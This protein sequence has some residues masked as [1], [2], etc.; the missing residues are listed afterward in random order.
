MI[1]DIQKRH[2]NRKYS[3]PR[4]RDLKRIAIDEISNSKG[5]T[6]LT[7]VLDLDSGRVVFVGKGKKEESLR[8]FWKRL[9]TS[10]TRRTNG[11]GWPRR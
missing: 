1:K 11:S 3:K 8:P 5:H 4:L 9:R 2:L 7:I 6:Y 10:T